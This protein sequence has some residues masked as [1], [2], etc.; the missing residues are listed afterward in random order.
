MTIVSFNLTYVHK[1]DSTLSSKKSTLDCLKDAVGKSSCM[2]TFSKYCF[3]AVGGHNL[4]WY[5]R[6]IDTLPKQWGRASAADYL[7][8]LQDKQVYHQVLLTTIDDIQL[9]HVLDPQALR[10]VLEP[11]LASLHVDTSVTCALKM[12]QCA[13]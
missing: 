7:Q 5:C 10:Q 1:T 11:L 8:Q 13:T 6:V 9:M 2:C 4:C 12:Q 3:C